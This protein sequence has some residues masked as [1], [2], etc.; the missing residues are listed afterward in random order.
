MDERGIFV[1]YASWSSVNLAGSMYVASSAI[2][3]AKFFGR[4]DATLAA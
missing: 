2:L 4:Y 1:C 3:S